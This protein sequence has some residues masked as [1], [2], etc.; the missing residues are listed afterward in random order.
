MNLDTRENL[1][2]SWADNTSDTDTDNDTTVR[3]IKSNSMNKSMNTHKS[4]NKSGNKSG[5]SSRHSNNK[6]KF[7][8]E[9]NFSHG[10]KTHR[11]FNFCDFRVVNVTPKLEHILNALNYDDQAIVTDMDKSH[12]IDQFPKFLRF[13]SGRNST[14]GFWC[15]VLKHT[16]DEQ[17]VFGNIYNT[18]FMGMIINELPYVFSCI[19]S[20]GDSP[21]KQHPSEFP[22]IH[23]W[24]I[25]KVPQNKVQE[26]ISLTIKK[27]LS[28]IQ[29]KEKNI[30]NMEKI[31]SDEKTKIANM[32]Q[33]VE[34]L[35]NVSN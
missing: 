8:N 2:G 35:A 4:G 20:V 19:V 6:T 3:I 11:P 31:I 1:T 27:Q 18:Y 13:N 22:M 14:C 15:P 25:W 30:L 28:L 21:W 23:M 10:K 9:P 33:T 17:K 24:K 5:S 32:K 29:S 34:L 16:E 26:V 7:H 12:G